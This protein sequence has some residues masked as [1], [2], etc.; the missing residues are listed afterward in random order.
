MIEVQAKW[1]ASV[2]SGKVILPPKEE[3]LHDVEQHYRLMEE[4]RIPK[5]HT[6]RLPLDPVIK[7]PDHSWVFVSSARFTTLQV[8][9]Y[10]MIVS[11]WQ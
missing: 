6:H 11:I 3:M 7:V 10:L 5:H 4:N 1:V 9:D 2:L 8:F